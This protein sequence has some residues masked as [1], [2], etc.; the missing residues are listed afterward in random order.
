[1]CNIYVYMDEKR[2]LFMDFKIEN[3]KNL[4]VEFKKN[5]KT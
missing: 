1:M 2:I 3:A 4:K 5:A